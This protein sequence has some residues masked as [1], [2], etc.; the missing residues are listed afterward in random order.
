M[1]FVHSSF[2]T[3]SVCRF[4][5]YRSTTFW[6][7]AMTR[8]SSVCWVWMDSREVVASETALRSSSF[9]VSLAIGEQQK[10]G[11]QRVACEFGRRE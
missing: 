7:R 8:P 6:D 5:M 9:L 4:E 1:S 11:R 3:L 2:R 10:E